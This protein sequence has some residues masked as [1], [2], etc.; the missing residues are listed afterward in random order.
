MKSVLVTANVL[1]SRWAAYVQ[2]T[3]VPKPRLE[4]ATKTMYR[5][6]NSNIVLRRGSETIEADKEEQ[7]YRGVYDV[8]IQQMRDV[9]F[10]K[11]IVRKVIVGSWYARPSL[12]WQ[13]PPVIRLINTKEII[14]ENFDKTIDIWQDRFI[15]RKPVPVGEL[16]FRFN[17]R[18]FRFQIKSRN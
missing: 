10:C 8:C 17:D 9:S 7:Y 11:D 6:R 18:N 15:E 16:I 3:T 13:W 12:D 4:I 5:L 2:Q 14:I 1:D